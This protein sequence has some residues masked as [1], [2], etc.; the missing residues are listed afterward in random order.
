VTVGSCGWF[1]LN[2]PNCDIMGYYCSDDLAKLA[3]IC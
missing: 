2:M 3:N 1:C